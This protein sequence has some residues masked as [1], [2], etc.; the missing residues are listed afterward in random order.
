[1][2]V[3]TNNSL[4]KRYWQK[5]NLFDGWIIGYRLHGLD[6]LIKIQIYKYK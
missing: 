5:Y 4:E 3:Y 1:M 2:H 6:W